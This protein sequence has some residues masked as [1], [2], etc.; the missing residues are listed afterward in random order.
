MKAFHRIFA[1][2]I[3]VL[4]ILFAIANVVLL[5]DNKD[6][7][8]PYRVEINRLARE[9]EANSFEQTDLTHCEYV[10]GVE[11]YSDNFYNSD[12]DYLIR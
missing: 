9:I 11:K 1:I 3:A 2:V 5:T 10:T 6:S 4:V 7:G 8:R 12:S